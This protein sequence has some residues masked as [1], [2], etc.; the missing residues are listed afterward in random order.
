MKIA[1]FLLCL[2]G[3]LFYLDSQANYLGKLI[4][5]Y[6]GVTASASLIAMFILCGLSL[7]SS[8]FGFL[9][10]YESLRKVSRVEIDEK[11]D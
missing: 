5:S 9:F 2:A 10:L 8:F 3:F 11:E 1:S 6:E 7:L 4:T